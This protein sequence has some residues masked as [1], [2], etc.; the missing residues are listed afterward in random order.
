MQAWVLDAFGLDNLKRAE[1][2]EAPCSARQVR[3]QFSAVAL[4][5][6]DLLVVTGQYNPRMRLPRIPVSDGVGT[7]VEAGSEVRRF[8]VGDRV[9][10]CF[11]PW[12]DDGD[13]SDAKLR[14]A[15]G[16]D[17]DGVLCQTAVFDETSVID[18]PPHLT[19]EQAATLPCAALTAWSALFE[20]GRLTAGDTVL[21]QGTGGV[22]IFALQFAIMA[23]LRVI[24]TSSREER[25][26]R[27]GAMGA[28]DTVNYRTAPRW[29]ER[30]RE[31]TGGAGVDLIV[32]V[33]GAGTLARSFKAVR[34]GGQVSLIG[35]L[36]GNQA[37]VN[38]LPVTMRNLRLQGILVG[39]R[40]SFARMNRAIAQHRL[41]PV[42]DSV[43]A[44]DEPVAALRYLES[45]QHFGKV[46]V[47]L[48]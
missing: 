43:F 35:V 44:F 5:Y 41:V 10:G 32:E 26:A 30:V 33:G 16:A 39:S 31:L 45:G 14:D 7:I 24:A 48:R 38:P 1:R 11:F 37:E 42:V 28:H 15:L 2:P 12:W 36:A 17:H 19:D 29:D 9:A 34:R 22:S 20:Q 25:L 40:A 18:V 27:L 46:V 23:G 4:N 3:V 13:C 21:V 6:R 47:R 8:K